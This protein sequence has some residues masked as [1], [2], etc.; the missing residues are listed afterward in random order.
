M[1]DAAA[2]ERLS[3]AGVDGDPLKL[4]ELV[5]R[6]AL[7]ELVASSAHIFGVPVRVASTTGALL[8]GPAVPGP[9]LPLCGDRGAR[10]ASEGLD[11][12]LSGGARTF[13]APTGESF[14]AV[15]LQYDHHPTGRVVIGPFTAPGADPPAA[16]AADLEPA[17][18]AWAAL[19]RLAAAR[20]EE[21]GAHLATTLEVMLFSGHKALVTSQMHL[22]STQESY[23]ELCEQNERLEEAYERLKELDRLKSNFLATVSHELRT[24]LTSIMGYGEMLAEGVAGALNEE[25]KEFV[26]TIRGKSEQLLGLIMSLLDMSKLENGTMPV[27]FG[28]LSIGDVIEEAVS[29]LVPTAMKKGVTIEP[30]VPADLPLV[31]GDGDRLRQVFIN[32]TDNAVKF[33]PPNGVVRIVARPTTVRPQGEPGLI[34]VAPLKPAIEVRV[35]DTGIGI[36]ED[37][38]ERVFDP[39]YQID[40]SSTREYGGAGLGLAIVKRLVE[41]HQGTIHVEGNEPSGAVFVVT[42]PS[43]RSSVLPPGRTSSVPP[44]RGSLPP[45]FG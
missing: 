43:G 4:E 16:L 18:D 19:P 38:R 10:I 14:R 36:A 29:T 12:D 34:L 30:D 21:I 9:I 15:P 22:A 28:R 35:I 32:L 40:Q 17:R 41:A 8:A 33:T 42:L 44:P 1:R 39:F 31:L 26:E 13:V 37:E 20:V 27:R 5:D 3:I 2:Q 24:P 7:R 11:V 23:R 45:V 25:Q 6:S